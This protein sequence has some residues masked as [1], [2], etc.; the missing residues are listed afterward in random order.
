MT[1]IAL[2]ISIVI[3]KSDKNQ[4]LETLDSLVLACNKSK[5]Y[6]YRIY[7]INN[8]R[9][10]PEYL[11]KINLKNLDILDGHGNIGYGAGHNL[12]SNNIG[13]YHLVL[14]PDVILDE[15]SILN[16]IK[17]MEE[18]PNI[19]LI[20][21]NTKNE[22]NKRQ[23][24]VKAYPSILIFF[25]RAINNKFLNKLF[26]KK[27]MNYECHNLNYKT[28]NKVIFCGGCFMFFRSNVFKQIK[29]FDEKYF[30]YFEDM[31][32]SYRSNLISENIY[33]PEVKITHFGGNAS[34]KGLSHW[35]YFIL[36][37]LIFFKKYGWKII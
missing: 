4:L 12:I 19:G 6:N 33:D 13:K 37:L 17:R 14:N 26:S 28:L 5:I 30:L 7:L 18:H 15:K 29:G 20:T 36:S 24:I 35:K 1:K 32:I 25:L 31:D 34:R 23:F 22:Y 27:L 21:P 9:F 3:Y 2:T 16:S 8:D 11:N 10:F